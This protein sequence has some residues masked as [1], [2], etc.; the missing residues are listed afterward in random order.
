MRWLVTSKL[1]LECVVK[2]NN[3]LRKFHIHKT[4]GLTRMIINSETPRLCI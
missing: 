1:M 3:L 2:H 4:H